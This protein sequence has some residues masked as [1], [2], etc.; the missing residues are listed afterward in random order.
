MHT[1]S[2]RF[3]HTLLAFITI[4]LGADIYGSHINVLSWQYWI[5]FAVV[6]AGI[7]YYAWADQLFIREIM[8]SQDALIDGYAKEMDRRIEQIRSLRMVAAN[9]QDEV[10]LLIQKAKSEK[11]SKTEE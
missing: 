11:I 2:K 6:T 10:S 7:N 5:G 3:W 4:F 8:R 1:Q 9:L